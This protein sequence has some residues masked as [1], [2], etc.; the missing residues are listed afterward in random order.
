MTIYGDKMINLKQTLKYFEYQICK[1][2]SLVV[3]DS[4][5]LSARLKRICG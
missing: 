2:R 5:F 3:S 1:V 4:Y